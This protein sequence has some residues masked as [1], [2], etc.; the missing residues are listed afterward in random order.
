MYFNCWT[1]CQKS[2]FSDK[3]QNMCLRMKLTGEGV[4][5]FIV[6]K[7]INVQQNPG[8]GAKVVCPKPRAYPYQQQKVYNIDGSQGKSVIKLKTKFALGS[9]KLTDLFLFFCKKYFD[10]II[11]YFIKSRNKWINLSSFKRS[12]NGKKSSFQFRPVHLSTYQRP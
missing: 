10:K 3:K 12:I 9:D 2:S 11:D 8:R 6:T 7:T 4:E 1:L 5:D